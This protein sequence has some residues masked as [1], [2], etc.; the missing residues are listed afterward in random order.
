MRKNPEDMERAMEL[1]RS[2]LGQ[3]LLA[4]LQQKDGGQMEQ[5]MREANAGDYE[6]AA[7]SIQSL[8]SSPEAQRLIKELGK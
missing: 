2:P 6:S 3:Q 8:L 4:L 1:A 7:Q 5:A